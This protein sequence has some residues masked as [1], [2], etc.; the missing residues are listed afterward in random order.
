MCWKVGTVATTSPIKKYNADVDA[1]CTTAVERIPENAWKLYPNPT[2]GKIHIDMNESVHKVVV[3]SILGKKIAII[4]D[5][6]NEIDLSAY[7]AG[8]YFITVT[9]I[10][11]AVATKPVLKK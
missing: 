3:S 5:E 2:K 11:G 4:N 9:D 1:S 7:P 10:N 6:I 8:M